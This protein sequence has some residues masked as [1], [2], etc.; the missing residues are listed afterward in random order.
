MYRAPITSIPPTIVYR[1]N[2]SFSKIVEKVIPKTGQ[3]K[4][5]REAFTASALSRRNHSCMD[6]IETGMISHISENRRLL[7]NWVVPL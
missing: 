3:R 4:S 2:G 7:L 1:L 6:R 5:Q